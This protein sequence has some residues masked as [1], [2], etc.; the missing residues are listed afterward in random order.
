[1]TVELNSANGDISVQRVKRTVRIVNESIQRRVHKRETGTRPMASYR[2]AKPSCHTTSPEDCPKCCTCALV[3]PDPVTTEI[4]FLVTMG[5]GY[6][7]VLSV[8]Y[9]SCDAFSTAMPH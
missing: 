1:M 6:G 8:L 7:S 5:N 4:P 9:P 2:M 3:V